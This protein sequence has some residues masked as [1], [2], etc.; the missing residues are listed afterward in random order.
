MTINAP[1]LPDHGL[2]FS[3][4]RA[5]RG[6]WSVGYLPSGEVVAVAHPLLASRPGG[7]NSIKE[8]FSGRVITAI[9]EE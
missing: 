9:L 6:L 8:Q 7:L 5:F 4:S 2:S 1:N 3:V